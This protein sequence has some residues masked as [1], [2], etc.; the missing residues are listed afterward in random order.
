MKVFILGAYGMLGLSLS[1][2]LNK[3]KYSVLRQGRTPSADIFI[4]NVNK[5][6]ILNSIRKYKPDLIINLIAATNSS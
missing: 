2:Y 1:A 5:D 4:E 3:R 6:S